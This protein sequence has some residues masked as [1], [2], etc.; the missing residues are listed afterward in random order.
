LVKT[1]DIVRMNPN[2][3]PEDRDRDL[4]GIVIEIQD[5]RAQVVWEL[6]PNIHTRGF[7]PVG[8]LVTAS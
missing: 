3:N 7:V 5:G 6:T 4:C 1:G 2:F 8:H